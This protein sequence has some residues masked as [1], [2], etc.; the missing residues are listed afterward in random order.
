MNFINLTPHTV[1]FN[2]GTQFSASGNIARVAA[3]FN[4]IF[5]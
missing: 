4:E 5:N 3:S 2:D 1:C